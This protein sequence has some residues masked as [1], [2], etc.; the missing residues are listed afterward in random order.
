MSFLSKVEP[1]NQNCQF[2]DTH[3]FKVKTPSNK[4]VALTKSTN[5]GIQV[6]GTLNQLFIRGSQTETKFQ[7]N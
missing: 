2:K 5:M 7:R 6:L 1:K 4:T 3:L